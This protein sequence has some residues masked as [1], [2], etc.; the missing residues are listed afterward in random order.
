MQWKGVAGV[1]K[2]VVVT[3]GARGLGLSITKQLL[4]NNYNV[5]AIARTESVT[6][7]ELACDNLILKRH[8]FTDLKGIHTLSKDLNALALTHFSSP[9][10]GLVNN[11][12]IGQ[13]GVLGTLHEQ[14]ISEILTVN[15]QAPILLTK[16]ISREMMLNSIAG[17]IV[18][19]GSII[20]STG[21]S[22]LS[23]YAASKA[24]MEGFT[25]SLARELGK[26]NITVNVVA[27]GFMQTDMTAALGR[28]DLEKIR[29]RS[30]LGELATTEAVANAGSYLLSAQAA[31]TTGTVLTVDGGSTA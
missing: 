1:R 24:A 10:Y 2:T 8:D 20:A 26:V 6:F 9:I 17:R 23:V 13:N 5:L 27:P 29:R 14:D 11:A 19:V 30:A 28:E 4:S 16:Y 7:Q 22:G 31:L 18:N 21:Y 3:G 12:A 15:V 25:R